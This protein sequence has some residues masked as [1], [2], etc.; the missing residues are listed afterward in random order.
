MNWTEIQY[1][2]HWGTEGG[3]ADTKHKISVLICCV[4]Y[5]ELYNTARE[6][7]GLYKLAIRMGYE[8]YFGVIL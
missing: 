4:V 8:R 7:K 3:I 2:K 1:Y 6:N 5:W